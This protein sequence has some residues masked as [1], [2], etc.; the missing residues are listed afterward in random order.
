MLIFYTESRTYKNTILVYNT[1]IDETAF[2]DFFY[3]RSVMLFTYAKSAK[4][5][6]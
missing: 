2:E 5:Q 4:L 6:R 3:C 1:N